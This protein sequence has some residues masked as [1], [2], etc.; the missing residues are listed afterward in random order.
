MRPIRPATITCMEEDPKLED[1]GI[2]GYAWLP[3]ERAP[4]P[5]ILAWYPSLAELEHWLASQNPPPEGKV[6]TLRSTKRRTGQM[7]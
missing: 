3:A 5:G 2:I 4:G 7:R 1:E 6:A